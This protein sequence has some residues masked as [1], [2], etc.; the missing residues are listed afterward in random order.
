MAK[1]FRRAAG[2]FGCQLEAK[3]I[4]PLEA[5]KG[6][7]WI[8]EKRGLEARIKRLGIEIPTQPEGG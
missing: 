7:S 4:C 3:N 2:P 1:R 8:Y 6:I 5:P